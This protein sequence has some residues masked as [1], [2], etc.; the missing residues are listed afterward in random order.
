MQYHVLSCVMQRSL[1]ASA[2]RL[3]QVVFAES[4]HCLVCFSSQPLF[5]CPPHDDF[6]HLVSSL[7]CARWHGWWERLSPFVLEQAFGRTVQFS[8]LVT[9]HKSVFLINTSSS[10]DF[11]ALEMWIG[12]ACLGG[13]VFHLHTCKNEYCCYV[14]NFLSWCLLWTCGTLSVSADGQHALSVCCTCGGFV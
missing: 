3:K 9:W 7:G 4:F 8:S 10:T 12:P 1:L 5:V 6:S 11:T 14:I 2:I 13:I